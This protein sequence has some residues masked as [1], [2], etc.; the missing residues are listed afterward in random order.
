MP[1]TQ[2]RGASTRGPIYVKQVAHKENQE[3]NIL[4]I[5]ARNPASRI[6]NTLYKPVEPYLFTPDYI[7]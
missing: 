4:R 2:K 5:P 6:L 3:E 1:G 7:T